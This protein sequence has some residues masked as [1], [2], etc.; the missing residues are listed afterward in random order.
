MNNASSLFE[1]WVGGGGRGDLNTTV[2]RRQIL[3][4]SAEPIFYPKCT[5]IW[6]NSKRRYE[7]E[8][9]S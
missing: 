4:L 6:D 2:A 5:F 8:N 9:L 1:D 3:S 7:K